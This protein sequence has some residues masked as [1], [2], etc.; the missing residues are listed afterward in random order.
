MGRSLGFLIERRRGMGWEL[1][2]VDALLAKRAFTRLEHVGYAPANPVYTVSPASE[3][4]AVLLGD[5]VRPPLGESGLPV[6][7]SEEARREV[8]AMAE[9]AYGEP[10][11]VLAAELIAHDWSA[12]NE[13]GE[14]SQDLE[15][16]AAHLKD[17]LAPLAESEEMRIVYF[18][19]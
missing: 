8:A 16:L 9:P 11:H 3:L 13:D 7:L 10:G 6:D 15:D 18:F 4:I 19:S 1:C 12:E 2:S 5:A 17:V 14:P